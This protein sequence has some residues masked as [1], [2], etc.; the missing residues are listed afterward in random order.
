[1]DT[2]D[3]PAPDIAATLTAFRAQLRADLAA[4]AIA[5]LLEATAAGLLRPAAVA[6]WLNPAA[7]GREPEPEASPPLPAVAADDPALDHFARHPATAALAALAGDLDSPLVRTLRASG[8]ARVAP[9]ASRGTLLGL[10]AVGPGAAPADGLLDALAT[11]A[12]LALHAAE[13]ARRQQAAEA[14]RASGAEELR[15]AR[16]IQRSLLP[17]TLPAPAGWEIAVHYQPARVV[18]GDLY[19]FVELPG[20]LLGLVFGDASDKGVPAALMMAAARTLLRA[21]AQRLVLPAQVLHRVNDALCDQLPPGTFVTCLYAILD[22]ASGRLRY[23]NAGQSPPYRCGPRGVTELR[24]SGWPLG[25]MPDRTYEEA[26]TILA[27]GDSVLCYSDGLIETHCPTRAMFG[28][29]R[30]AEILAA[31]HPGEPLIATV[32][33]AH[34]AFAGPVWE[35]EDDLTLVAIARGPSPSPAP[36]PPVAGGSG[37]GGPRLLAAFTLLSAPGNERLAA[38]RVCAAVHALSLS[39]ARRERLHTAVAEAVMNAIEHGNDN[40]PELPVTVQVL[41]AADRLLVRVGDAG[42][43][44][45]PPAPTTPDLAAQLAGRQPP[46]GWG[47]SLIRQMVDEVHWITTPAGRTMELVLGYR[48]GER[49]A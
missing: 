11:E 10:L 30:L 23:A 5:R 41:A 22:P 35:Q 20:G 2:N 32:R 19:D 31:H 15:I 7:I 6:V 24:A 21:A 16:E 8:M 46:R 25:M 4:P 40:R 37:D 14:E 43:D 3:C 47:L 45:P 39:P 29:P 44:G 49:P 27:P 12:A 9:L 34:A 1:M 26:E 18:G 42:G 28:T 48:E 13:L 17:R 38:D 33:G 36:P